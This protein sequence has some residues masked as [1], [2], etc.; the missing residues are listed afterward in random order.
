MIVQSDNSAMYLLG[1]EEPDAIDKVFST[2]R[3]LYPLEN[4]GD[5]MSAATYS[6]LFRTLYNSTYLSRPDSEE[7]L[8]L[9]SYTNFRRGLVQGTATTTVSHKFGEQTIEGGE[10]DQK[11]LHDCGIVY[12]PEK[13]YFLCVM[14][15]GEDFGKLEKVIGGI[16]KLVFTHI[17]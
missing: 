8:R 5:F 14:T 16:S 9:L 15:K 10:I 13:P 3:I 12:Y 6:R 4:Q 2:L 1:R 17:H 11:E 7:A